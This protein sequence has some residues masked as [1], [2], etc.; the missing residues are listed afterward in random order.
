M[1][2]KQ[3]NKWITCKSKEK[4]YKQNSKNITINKEQIIL[5]IIITDIKIIIAIDIEIDKKKLI[6]IFN[7]FYQ[8][9]M[10]KYH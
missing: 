1:L 10:L 2:K 3:Q 8:I 6:W 9:Y 5:N 7:D 4:L